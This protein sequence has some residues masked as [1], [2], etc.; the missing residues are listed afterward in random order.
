[1]PH[2]RRCRPAPGPGSRGSPLRAA[3]RHAQGVDSVTEQRQDG[4]QEG[5]RG[6][7]R[8]QHDEDHAQAHA[9]GDGEGHHEHARECDDDREAA[10][11]HRAA[12]GGGRV[13]DG[14]DDARACRPLLAEAGDDEERVVDADGKAHR[15]YHVGG[16]D[17]HRERLPE[18]R[19][20]GEG[21]EYGAQGKRG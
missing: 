12:R 20:N 17:R 5:Q 8:D 3:E 11:Q 18:Q 14:I 6:G 1:M 9:D 2:E 21:G 19:D 10:Y 13:A 15:R 16:E 7:D 4:R